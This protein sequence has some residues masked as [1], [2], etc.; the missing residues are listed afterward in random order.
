MVSSSTL[1][2]VKAAFVKIR[3]Y[4]VYAHP[5]TPASINSADGSTGLP[6]SASRHLFTLLVVLTLALF[7]L[8][9]QFYFYR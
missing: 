9:N 5:A 6:A 7:V 8:S 2:Y 1:D 4:V 3:A